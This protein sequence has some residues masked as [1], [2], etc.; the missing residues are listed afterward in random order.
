MA[1]ERDVVWIQDAS[2]S[3]ILLRLSTVES[4]EEISHGG[5]FWMIHT[6]VMTQ[7]VII[8]PKNKCQELVKALDELKWIDYNGEDDDE[9]IDEDAESNV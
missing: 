8:A 1:D 7:G 4:I 3:R 5:A 6:N 2:G 9:D